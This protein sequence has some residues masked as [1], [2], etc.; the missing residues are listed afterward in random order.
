MIAFDNGPRDGDFARYIDR[1]VQD[2]ARAAAAGVATGVATDT[3]SMARRGSP[4]ADDP[5]APAAGGDPRWRAV[6]SPTAGRSTAARGVQTNAAVSN[7]DPVA[8]RAA[9]AAQGFRARPADNSNPD[10]TSR[11]PVRPATTAAALGNLVSVVALPIGIALLLIGIFVPTASVVVVLAGVLT[12]V[13]ATRR[14]ARSGAA[15]AFR[16]G[17]AGRDLT[18]R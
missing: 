4:S 5:F 10:G 13:W 14:L 11:S 18:G 12:L 9:M 17:R 7:R 6:A 3:D 16:T 1:I 8:A 15:A 2:R